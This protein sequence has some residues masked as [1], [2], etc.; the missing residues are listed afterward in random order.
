M[1]LT[2]GG[3]LLGWAEFTVRAELQILGL[4]I[5]IGG[6]L[7]LALGMTLRLGQSEERFIVPSTKHR[8]DPKS[9]NSRTG[10]HARRPVHHQ[11]DKAA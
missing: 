6:V 5:A 7:M 2:C 10:P 1:A 9:P 4:V 8:V 11:S 3:S